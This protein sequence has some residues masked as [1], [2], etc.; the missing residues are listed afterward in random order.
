MNALLFVFLAFP[1]FSYL[2]FSLIPSG[3]ITLFYFS[4]FVCLGVC[5]FIS[6]KNRIQTIPF[7]K[8]KIVI[9]TVFAAI[10]LFAVLYHDYYRWQVEPNGMLDSVLL[11]NVKA[12]LIGGAFLNSEPI[13]FH[14]SFWKFDSYPI[15]L[16]LTLGF[17]VVLNGGWSLYISYVYAIF[18]SL[19]CLA[20]FF[21][22][23]TQFINS[24]KELL[25]AGI[26]FLAFLLE[27]NTLMN[28][29]SLVADFPIFVGVFCLA[30]LYF[31]EWTNWTP[32]LF[33]LNLGW[34]LFT[35]NEGIFYLPTGILL[36][37]LK[38]KSKDSAPKI[39]SIFLNRDSVIFLLL[40]ALTLLPILFHKFQSGIVP[41]DFQRETPIQWTFSLFLD[42]LTW[43]VSYFVQFHFSFLLGIHFLILFLY[44]LLAEKN[45]E[46]FCIVGILLALPFIYTIPYLF[47]N[48][49]HSEAAKFLGQAYQNMT[50]VEKEIYHM[51]EHLESSFHRINTHYLPLFLML[52]LNIFKRGFLR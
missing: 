36:F 15:G 26:L 32:I 19:L 8:A 27:F 44:I 40:L 7:T 13:P 41:L 37:F 16:P 52:S 25:L 4:F 11:W 10:F 6:F 9:Y 39:S 48:Y 31:S 22:F 24:R 30:Y 35:K 50:Q 51:K 49:D 29:S 23:V 17:F 42:K 14:D 45:F 21:S 5:I 12:K 34:L 46:M 38:L 18:L 3:N 33:A 20:L 28:H 1:F 43:I 47:S 2:C